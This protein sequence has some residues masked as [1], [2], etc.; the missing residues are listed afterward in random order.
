MPVHLA[1]LALSVARCPEV[2][3]AA[4]DPD[5]PCHKVVSY[6]DRFDAPFQVPEAWAGSIETAKVVFLSSNPSIGAA[7]PNA[8]KD[9]MR[10]AELY[11]TK[12]WGDEL[13]ADFM[14]NRFDSPNQWVN[15][16]LQH[17]K[18][19]SESEPPEEILRRVI[20]GEPVRRG[21]S[22]NYWNWIKTQTQKLVGANEPWHQA[23]AMTEV[24]HCKS[25]KEHGA[26]EAAPLCSR[27]HMGPVFSAAPAGLVVVVGHAARDAFF[28][29]QPHLRRQYPE[30]G[31]NKGDHRP[32]PAQNI[33]EVELGGSVRTV[34]FLWHIQSWGKIKDLEDLYPQ[35]FHRLRAAALGVHPA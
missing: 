27:L 35:D 34:C 28:I 24:V 15:D 11:P 23:M 2:P 13:T 9:H 3:L 25:K 19:G 12:D 29:A 31:V 14:L 32:D 10:R 7:D 26:K 5:H 20:A 6:Q 17:L 18:A 21:P 30:F 8:K 1:E 33:F 22:E 16:E 4:V